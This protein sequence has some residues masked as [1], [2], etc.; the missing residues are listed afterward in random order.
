MEWWCSFG[1][2]NL[3]WRRR[4]LDPG[5]DG[6]GKKG[7]PGCFHRREMRNCYG[8][9]KKWDSLGEIVSTGCGLFA[10]EFAQ[11]LTGEE[12]GD[13]IKERSREIYFESKNKAS[14]S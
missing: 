12:L 8:P 3:F 11:F 10:K 13:H 4:L 9:E 2:V 6:R 1:R 14:R 5:V 7:V